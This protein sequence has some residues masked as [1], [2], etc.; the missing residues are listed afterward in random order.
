MGFNFNFN[1]LTNYSFKSRAFQ[2]PSFG[3]TYT[4]AKYTPTF[5]TSTYST[6]TK[7]SSL[8][9][10]MTLLTSLRTKFSPK[11]LKTYG[12]T[13]KTEP[14]VLKDTPLSLDEDFTVM[15][16]YGIVCPKDAK[17]SEIIEAKYLANYGIVCPPKEE[18]PVNPKETKFRSDDTRMYANYGIVCSPVEEDTFI[19]T[20]QFRS[21]DLRMCA[22]YGIV[23]PSDIS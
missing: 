4:Q 11:I 12:D 21:D 8:S 20:T 3:T 14:V 1:F 23:C 16:N 10:I 5:S 13:T 7:S 19:S 22:N 6:G 2:F 9:D 18:V 17:D 15:Q